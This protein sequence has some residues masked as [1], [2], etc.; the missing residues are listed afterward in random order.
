MQSVI[1][2]DDDG[3]VHIFGLRKFPK[4]QIG[5]GAQVFSLNKLYDELLV[6]DWSLHV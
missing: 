6:N 4:P 5:R 3:G 2:G 1:I